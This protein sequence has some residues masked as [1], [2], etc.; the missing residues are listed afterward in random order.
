MT[1]ADRMTDKDAHVY[2]ATGLDAPLDESLNWMPGER[3]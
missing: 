3:T 1:G 2:M